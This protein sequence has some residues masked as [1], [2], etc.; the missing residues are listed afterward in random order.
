M[1]EKENPKPDAPLW[2]RS[3]DRGKRYSFNRPG[4]LQRLEWLVGNSVEY[5]PDRQVIAEQWLPSMYRFDAPFI[6]PKR[7]AIKLG[8]TD[9]E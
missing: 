2:P 6:F 7:T 9:S 3:K 1:K 4:A 8:W 5:A